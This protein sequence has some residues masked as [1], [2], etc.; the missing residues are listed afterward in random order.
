MQTEKESI[1][2]QDILKFALLQNAAECYLDG[3]LFDNSDAI[4]E[5]LNRLLIFS[6]KPSFFVLK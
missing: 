1:K 5:R 6:K 2:A 3:I 4:H